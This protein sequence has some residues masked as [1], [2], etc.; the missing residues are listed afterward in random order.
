[1]EKGGGWLIKSIDEIMRNYEK[2]QQVHILDILVEVNREVGSRETEE[3]EKMYEIPKLDFKI[4]ME[5]LPTGLK[6]HVKELREICSK[7]SSKVEIN[8]CQVELDE[9]AAKIDQIGHTED[10]FNRIKDEIVLLTEKFIQK[11]RYVPSKSQSSF[12]HNLA[13]NDEDLF[14]CKIK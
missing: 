14:L 6:N 12:F 10:S 2:R 9:L 8:K 11:L 7:P 3:G 13:F 1:M 4:K 5:N